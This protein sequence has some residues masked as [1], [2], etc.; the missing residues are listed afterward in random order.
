MKHILLLFAIA[1]SGWAQIFQIPLPSSSGG[2]PPADCGD[3]SVQL[4]ASSTTLGCD[5]AFKINTTTHAF[6]VDDG[7]I[8]VNRTMDD[9][10]TPIVAS[11]C[12]A[13]LPP[14]TNTALVLVADCQEDYDFFDGYAGTSISDLTL[15]VS[16]AYGD[17]TKRNGFILLRSGDATQINLNSDTG[18]Q[19]AATSDVVVARVKRKMGQTADLLDLL[20]SD[21][22]TKLSFFDASGNLS[23]VPQKA[24]TGQ[25]FACITTTGEIVSSVTA[26]SGT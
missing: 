2:A 15:A 16:I 10:I 5:A 22:T 6:N 21:G 25:R 3:G 20:D 23:L 4:F 13:Q 24:T 11:H 19:F 8:S 18:S 1:A 26:C 12:N 17:A 14:D 9:F 7:Y